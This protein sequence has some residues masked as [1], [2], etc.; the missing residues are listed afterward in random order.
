[1]KQVKAKVI[2]IGRHIDGLYRPSG[3]SIEL[4]QTITLRCPEIASEAKPGQFIMIKCGNDYILPRPV[5]I[6]RSINGEDL[7][8]YFAVLE[9]GKGTNWLSSR[10]IKDEINIFGPLGNEYSINRTAKNLL[11][12]A[13][14]MG[15]ASLY[16]LAEDKV[17][18]GYSIR[19][20]YGTAIQ[21]SYPGEISDSR[22]EMIIATEDGSAGYHGM[23]TDL[24]PEHI[25][26]AD[27]VFACGPVGMY[28]AMA[29]MPELKNKPVQVSLEVRMGCGR[30]ICYGCT[31]KT[32]NG[33]KRVCED[34]PV[35]NLDEVIWDSVV[36]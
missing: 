7:V 30:G 9:N 20:L 27:Q 2:S 12:V 32:K 16:Y 35:F 3:R 13:G 18:K 26:W 19:L 15:V 1:L 23:I 4:S 10:E 22:I 14:G 17:N 28:K 33:L 36:L 34:G 24:I 6:H 21:N 29:Q 31:I 8:L 11:L 5:S 25:D